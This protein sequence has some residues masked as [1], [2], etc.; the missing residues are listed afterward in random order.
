ML[1]STAFPPIAT[2]PY[3]ITLAPYGFFWF[4]LVRD[5]ANTAAPSRSRALPELPTVV[6]PRTGLAFDRWARA[7]IET[8]VLPLPGGQGRVRDAFPAG[9]LDPEL[10]FVVVGDA[11][12]AVSLPLRFV[13]DEPLREDALARARSGPHEGWI[14]D[15]GDDGATA[16]IVERAMRA[17]TTLS[18][19]GRLVFGLEGEPPREATSSQRL[20]SASGAQRW[21]LDDARLV[22]LHRAMPRVEDSTVVFLRHLR[23]TRLRRHPVAVRHRALRRRRRRGAGGRRPR[24]ASSTTR[25]TPSPR[26]ARCSR[27]GPPTS[28]CC[29]APRSSPSA[30]PRS[31]ARWPR[32]AATPASPPSRCAPADLAGWQATAHADLAALVGA[33][34]PGTEELRERV[35]RA[36]D[37]LP[38]HISAAA[39]RAHGRMTLGRVLL[40][41]GQP[42]FVGFGE[43]VAA[44]SSPLKDVASLTRSFEAV[45]RE[46]VAASAYDP[47]TDPAETR[48]AAADI[49]AR[50]RAAFLRRYFERAAGLPTI[51]ADPARARRAAALLPGRPVDPRGARRLRPHARHAARRRRGTGRRV[52]LTATC[53]GRPPGGNRQCRDS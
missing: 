4:A 33:R 31:T 38:A 29:A 45:A 32:P 53:A 13:W 43:P 34:T 27:P 30:W 49:T 41:D 37:E 24:S 6:V 28:G 36:I 48:S 35:T 22:T 19:R 39:G 51:P 10:A 7:V 12:R 42:V 17:G 44:K 52:P 47:T 25:P 20:G 26:C 18:D 8:D 11:E 2:G 14:V 46:S 23:E 40:V 16:L 21:I 50:A 1:G 9:G 3:T 5:P 15:A